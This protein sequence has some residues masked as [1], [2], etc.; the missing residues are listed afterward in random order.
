MI[1]QIGDVAH[2]LATRSLE[3]GDVRRARMASAVGRM[4]DPI[5]EVYWRDSL[6]A[7]F[8]AGDTAGI[9][10]LIT[11]LEQHLADIDEGYE[12]D[13]ETQAL[14]DQLRGRYAEAA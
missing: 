5:T 8:Q 14:I 11:Q 12:P 10:R 2:E 9:E 13:P 3:N 7:E 1:C 4:V 6:R